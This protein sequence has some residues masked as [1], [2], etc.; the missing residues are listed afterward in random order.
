MRMPKYYKPNFQLSAAILAGG[1]SRRMGK[2]KALLKIEDLPI[3]NRVTKVASQVARELIIVVSENQSSFDAI[4][5]RIVVDQT[6]EKGPLM[7]IFTALQSV[8][9]S[10]CLILACDLPLIK[11]EVLIEMSQKLGSHDV[12][13]PLTDNGFE[14]LCAIYAQ[15]CLPVIASKINQNQ[16]SVHRLFS[17][18]NIYSFTEWRDIDP[19][20]NIFLNMNTPNDYQKARQILAQNC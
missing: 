19:T 4:Q 16:L 17:E 1:K 14:P 2:P 13:V 8:S 12:I 18:L 6:P 10:H 20:G 7:A 15:S 5:A 9:N 3:I 11:A